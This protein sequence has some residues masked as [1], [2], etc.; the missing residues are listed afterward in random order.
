MAQGFAGN[1]PLQSENG[2]K[3]LVERT[4]ELRA[5]D[6]DVRELLAALLDEVKEIRLFL[7]SI[8]N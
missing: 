6:K 1:K 8:T 5:Q 3:V 7:I 2:E 4:Q